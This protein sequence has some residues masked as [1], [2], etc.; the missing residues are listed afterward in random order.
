MERGSMFS[1]GGRYLHELL[2]RFRGTWNLPFTAQRYLR[3]AIPGLTSRKLANSLRALAE[4]KLGR[5]AVLSKPFV[6]R[7]EP[8][9]VCNLRCP[10]CACGIYTDPRPKGFMDLDDYRLV[11][12]QNRADAI[13]IRL[14]GM[15]EPTLHPKIFEMMEMAKQ[16][17]FSV[18]MSTNFCTKSCADVHAFIESGLDRL[19]IPI[20]GSTQASYERY[21]VGGDLALVENRLAELLSLR[22]R[23]GSKHPF[24]EVQFLDWGYN[25]DEIPEIRRKA[26]EWGA[27][28]FEIIEPDWAV[29]NAHVDPDRPRRCFWLWCV[30]TVDWEL[31]YRACTNAWT[32]PWPRLNLRNVHTHDFWNSEVMVEA[33]RYNVSKRSDIIARDKGCNCNDCS[34][35]LVVDRP[36][37]FVCR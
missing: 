21:R 36:D 3:T 18:S 26:R 23:M 11:L 22:R 1:G 37:E 13:T 29:T 17:G 24:T 19:V 35:M 27:D 9:N 7:I 30:L 12:T 5:T 34:D 16:L 31:N 14:D 33:R 10:R 4:M 32:Y 20:D 6:L 2:F 15:G 25:H 8:A 28:K